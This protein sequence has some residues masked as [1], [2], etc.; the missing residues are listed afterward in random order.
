MWGFAGGRSPPAKP[1]IFFRPLPNGAH[2]VGEGAGGG[3]KASKSQ[4]FI[5]RCLAAW[6]QAKQLRDLKDYDHEQYR[7]SGPKFGPVGF[8]GGVSEKRFLAH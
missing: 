6:R 4:K 2:A 7:F 3:E 1:F 8:C 5:H